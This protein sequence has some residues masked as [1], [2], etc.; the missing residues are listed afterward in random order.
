PASRA[1]ANGAQIP[2]A[3][4]RSRP[5]REDKAAQPQG[6]AKAP[7]QSAEG[8]RPPRDREALQRRS[9]EERQRLREQFPDKRGE[10]A[11]GKGVPARGAGAAA[12]Q[13]MQSPRKA[14]VR[15]M[16]ADGSIQ[17]REITIGVTNRIHA[18]VLS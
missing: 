14:T 18:E 12:G 15:V 6:T 16:A 13:P 11:G 17:E 10:R 2:V 4:K 9:P 8:K 1:S 7:Q 5:S 3:D